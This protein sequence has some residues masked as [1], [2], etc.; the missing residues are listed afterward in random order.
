MQAFLDE[1]VR[2]GDPGLYVLAAVVV[3]RDRADDIRHQLRASLPGRRS[4]AH[5]REYDEPRRRKFV[6]DLM[7]FHLTSVVAVASPVDPR[8]QERARR[9]CLKRL[10]WELD[11]AGILDVV[12]E[13][14]RDQD[15]ADQKHILH[16]QADGHV[17]ATLVYGFAQPLTEPLLWLPDAVAGAVSMAY[18][19]L[20][21][22]HLDRMGPM[23]MVVHVGSAA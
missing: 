11:Q 3:P 1:S 5:W 4:R 9:H 6:E 8:R 10:L 17:S 20:A 14:R 18:G 15:L 13:S 21:Q 12:L 22:D 23:V 19:E 7:G 16:C 2:S